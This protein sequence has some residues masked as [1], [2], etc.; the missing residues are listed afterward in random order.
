MIKP[1]ECTQCGSTDFEDV[2]AERVR[3]AHCGSLF[4]VLT[5]APGI[6]IRRGANVTFGADA[7]VEIRGSMEIES[8]AS[9]DIEGDV[10][11]VKGKGK[12]KRRFR[13]K[14]IA[15]EDPGVLPAA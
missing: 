8:G 12:R 5:D 10:T 13:L 1:Y 14:R 15:E 9:V 7:K 4:R 3:C 6:V 11:V 2:S